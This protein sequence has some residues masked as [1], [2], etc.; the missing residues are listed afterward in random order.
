MEDPVVSGY[1][2][3]IQTRFTK[4]IFQD[5]AKKTLPVAI[6]FLH[7]LQKVQNTKKNQLHSYTHLTPEY[8]LVKGFQKGITLGY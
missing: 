4:R 8:D 2:S 3:H 6:Y 5:L 1:F 7:F